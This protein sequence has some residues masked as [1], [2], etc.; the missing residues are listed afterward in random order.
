MLAVTR[1]TLNQESA[2]SGVQELPV[3]GWE[4][5]SPRR[6]VRQTAYRIQ[7]SHEKSFD[8]ILLHSEWQQCEH[9][10]NVT[11]T[12]LM[13]TS[14]QRYFIRVQVRDD[15]GETSNWSSAAEM[16]SG[17]L[18]PHEWLADFIS[19][20]KPADKIHSA[21]TLLR[22]SFVLNRAEEIQSAFIHV[23]ALGLY[24]LH[25]NGLKVGEDALT[26]GWTSYHNHL[27]YQTYNLTGYLNK[28][29][30]VLG[31]ITGAGWYKG[32][33]GFSRHR[34]YYGE[35][36]ALI[37]QL[38]INYKDGTQDIVVSDE[39]WKAHDSAIIFSEIYDGEIYDARREVSGWCEK[40]F[41]G[42]G[43]RPVSL[44]THEKSTLVAQGSNTVRKM[45][46]LKPVQM[47]TTPQGD[48]VIDFGQNLSGWVEFNVRGNAGDKVVLRHFEVLD[49][50][51]N[52]YLDNLRTATQRTEYVL[53]GEGE[54][55]WHP[56]FTWQGF[57]YVKVEE[58]P[59][60]LD[61]TNFTAI[62][63][64]SAMEQTGYFACSNPQLNQLHHNILWGLKGNFVDVP[65]DCPQRDERLGWTGDA[66]IFC[67]TAS[68]LMQTR[69]FFAKWLTDLR[70]DQTPE[71][72]VPH[73]I[74]DILTGHC[75]KDRLLSE[76]GTHSASAWADAAVINPWTM[77]LM[78]G[79]TKVL[80]N[81]YASMKG[82]ID[83]MT[84]HAENHIWH[85][86]LQFGDWVALDAKEGSYFGATPNDLTCTAYYAYS[87][88]LFAK[89]AK[90]LKRDADFEHYD[91]LHQAIVRRFQEEFFT[92][93]GRLAA[94]TQTAH[95]LALYFNLVPEA[96]R[97]RTTDTLVE[98][99]NEHDGHLVTGFVGT[100]YFCHALSQ[101]GRIKEAWNLLLKDDF[102]S[103]L[104]Q[105]KAGA[106]T[107]WEH[108][109]G[110]KPD[111]SM[112]S[113]DMNSFNHYAYG[114][115]GE[116]LYRVAAG[117]EADE[118]HP[119]FKHFIIK[120][121]TGGG[122]SWLETRY[123]SVYGAIGVRWEV[124]G[125][126]VSLCVKVPANTSATL[127]LTDGEALLE[128]DGVDFIR[129][130]EG[131]SAEIGSGEYRLKYHVAD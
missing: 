85:Y 52:V 61:L 106:T 43:W 95:I 37:S 2:L 102:P 25:L 55:T 98:L 76:G 109:D 60:R 87:T 11:L 40:G 24:E 29:E 105:V 44:M 107:I 12:E 3:L 112:W 116:W 67:R 91:A 128:A 66:Q 131:F 93:S 28:G 13:M 21:G 18:Y 123:Q 17:V 113:A 127:V 14:S 64:H 59:A 20:E 130:T 22:K 27:L 30:N 75:E 54:E 114:A 81:Q 46:E 65:T 125:K 69:N 62:V 31:A 92:P 39:S 38:I 57:R 100:P 96:F 77:Y 108:W 89:T 117:I 126:E 70:Y 9:S 8:N 83:F 74:P 119:G 50:D 4:I 35:Q 80:E 19:G 118:E 5:E 71:G 103:W 129:N 73:V 122:L 51:G 48:T 121:L 97:E 41:S 23:S 56:H 58:Y 16:I 78:Y 110:I 90:V 53:K 82:W 68:Y 34:N 101:N 36:T 94:R 72:G 120:P 47:I 84:A 86:S 111:G 33:M 7:V 10:N 79:D 115:V 49:A 1:L 88:Q 26:P 63:L 124:S 15:Q 32:D 45:E 42:D 99:L 6:N 104:Y